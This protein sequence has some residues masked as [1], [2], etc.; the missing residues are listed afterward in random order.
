[1]L[2]IYRR[3][4]KNCKH[5]AK[6]RQYRHCHCPIWVD[7]FLGSK[8][9]RESLKMRDWRRAQE[10]IRDWEADDRRATQPTL[11][12]T[13]DAWTEFLADIEARK[14]HSST[15]RKYKLLKRQMEDFAKGRGM[16]FLTD[17]DLSKVSQFRAG[18]KDGPRSSAK[19]L[20]RLRAF[21]RFAQ[22]RKWV[23][24][25]PALDLKAPKVTLCPTLPFSCEEMVRI[26]AA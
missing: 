24:E 23:P 1:M 15:V 2:T 26:L 12:P 17:F 11:K 25:N 10:K 14:L 19:K 5:R 13:E 3:H 16:R 6:G 22:K 7:G 4:M 21:F 20:E 18:W 9:L 8:E